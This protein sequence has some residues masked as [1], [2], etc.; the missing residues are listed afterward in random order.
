M[1]LPSWQGQSNRNFQLWRLTLFWDLTC[2]S[3]HMMMWITKLIW[4]T[5]VS[6]ALSRYGSTA[7]FILRN[8]RKLFNRSWKKLRFVWWGSGLFLCIFQGLRT[9][10]LIL[11]PTK[12]EQNSLTTCISWLTYLEITVCHLFLSAAVSLLQWLVFEADSPTALPYAVPQV[13]FTKLEESSYKKCEL[14]SV[15]EMKGFFSD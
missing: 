9:A 5:S 4:N 13:S 14:Q 3:A 1:D 6:N 7:A 2:E 12:K 10:E 8:T 15:L 11:F